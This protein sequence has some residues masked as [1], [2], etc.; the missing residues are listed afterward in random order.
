VAFLP[1]HDQVYSALFSRDG[2]LLVTLSLDNFAKVWDVA[3]GKLLARLDGHLGQ[4]ASAAFT[5]DGRTLI[6]GSQDRTARIWDLGLET[7]APA[8]VRAF[9]R[10]KAPWTL[11]E[12]RLVNA[13]VPSSGC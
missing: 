9:A 4:I 11:Q 5:A 2:A 8:E 10:C 3:G 1:G 12:G 7:R 6:T 13:A